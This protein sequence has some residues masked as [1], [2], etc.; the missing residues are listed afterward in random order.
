MKLKKPP[1]DGVLF[2]Q[3]GGWAVV[4]RNNTRLERRCTWRVHRRGERQVCGQP[5]DVFVTKLSEWRCPRSH[6]V[7]ETS[8]R[9]L[10]VSRTR[11]DYTLKK[12]G[13]AKV[14]KVRRVYLRATVDD[15][16]LYLARIAGWAF[17][18]GARYAGVSWA[19]F[20]RPRRLEVDHTNGNWASCLSTS[21]E[22]VTAAEN[23]RRWLQRLC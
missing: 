13:D 17:G 22:V 23:R 9:G 3:K 16:Q 11:K 8:L 14:T 1:R 10:A 5:C 15:R 6:K 12:S 21:L 4:Q 2:G 19:E 18:R 7:Q 20:C